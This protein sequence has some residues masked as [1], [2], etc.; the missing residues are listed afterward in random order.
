VADVVNGL[1]A[2][3]SVACERVEAADIVARVRS[4]SRLGHLL[5]ARAAKRQGLLANDLTALMRIVEWGGVS[6]TVL[7]QSLPLDQSSITELADRLQRHGLITR[8][9][10]PTDRRLV[11]LTPTEKG[12]RTVRDAVGPLFAELT[13]LLDSMPDDD[14][15]AVWRFVQRVDNVL[16][17]LTEG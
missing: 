9:R 4:A 16:S 5:V 14:R 17:S 7:A 1:N 12:E 15:D 3:A 11:L 2:H 13:E 8:A 6:P 10:V